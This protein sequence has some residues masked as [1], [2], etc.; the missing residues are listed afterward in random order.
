LS[1]DYVPIIIYSNYK[2][3]SQENILF[4]KQ[5]VKKK[6]M[7]RWLL[8]VFSYIFSFVVYT[9]F[10]NWKVSLI[11]CIGIAFHECGHLYAAKMKGMATKGFFLIPFI[12]GLALIAGRYRKYAD[13]AFVAIAGP[14]AGTVL[15]LGFLAAYYLTG[16]PLLGNAG[17]WMAWLNLLNLIPLAMLDGGQVVESIIYSIEETAGA[18]YLTLSYI[19][20][21]FVLWHFNLALSGVVIFFGVGTIFQAWTRVNWIRQGW[22]YMLPKRPNR[23]SVLEIVVTLTSYLGITLILLNLISMFANYGMSLDLEGLLHY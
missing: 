18:I 10:L 19:L 23:M 14:I 20:A 12:G 4:L 17:Y 1:G 11:L 16:S 8:Q 13:L 5:K 2:S 6:T 22:E 15:T 3:S 21:A 7:P 9:T